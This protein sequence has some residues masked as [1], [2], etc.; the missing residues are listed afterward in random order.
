MADTAFEI[1]IKCLLGSKERADALREKLHESDPRIISHG[2]HAQRNHYFIGGDMQKLFVNV[3]PYLE[4]EKSAALAGLVPE[5]TNFSLRAREADGKVMLVIKAAIDDTTSANGI[6]RME[7]EG[8]TPSLTLETLDDLLLKAGFSY[9][10][11]WSRER[12][13]YGYRGINVTID[14]NA[15]YGYLAEFE[16]MC[17]TAED[18]PSARVNLVTIMQ[19]LGVEAL[20]QD[21]LERMFA[22]YNAHWPE[23]YGTNNFFTI[24]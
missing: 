22:Y 17:R 13:E 7:F 15:G 19:E 14:K 5:I 12:E 1:E 3:S 23:Y 11:K 16:T 2:H 20:P 8:M 24:N 9:Q 6:A 21:R 18:A 10:A 4:Q